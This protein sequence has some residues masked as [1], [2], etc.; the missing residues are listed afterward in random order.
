[1]GLEYAGKFI[2][3]G[4]SSFD[5]I[6]DR[7]KAP[8]LMIK[9]QILYVTTNYYLNFYY[10]SF[11]TYPVEYDLQLWSVQQKIMDCAKKNPEINIAIKLH[12]GHVDRKP[13]N[14]YKTDNNISNI[15]LVVSESSVSEMVEASDMVILDLVSTSILQVLRYNKPVFVYTGNSPPDPGPARLLRKRAYVYDREDDFADAITRFIRKDRFP[16]TDDERLVDLNNTEFLQS[17][18]THLNDGKSADRAA[19]FLKKILKNEN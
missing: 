16:L 13:L 10:I 2:P 12:P 8:N 6:N 19:A 1:M 3:I 5:R 14:E 15:Y 17:Y 9:D 7:D 11:P 18:G 4:S